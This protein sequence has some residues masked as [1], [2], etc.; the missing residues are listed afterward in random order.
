MWSKTKKALNDR[1]AVSLKKH[2]RYNF[3]VYVTNKY[4]WYTE[5]PV[6]YIYVD[7][8]LWFATNPEYYVKNWEYIQKNMDY[9]LTDN[10][11]WEAFDKLRPDAVAY[12]SSHGLMEIDEM[13]S[14]IHAYLNIFS[15]KDCLSSGNY[16]LMMLAVLDR[17]A[18]KRKI[19][20][21][22]DDIDN[23]PEWL[24]KFIILRAECEGIHCSSIK[25]N[26]Q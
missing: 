23:E 4:K 15:I 3:E 2:V 21:L 13:M 22:L 14:I 25:E 26:K 8:E 5:M 17:R 6:F 7:D 19:K 24:R 10:E 12:A 16:I 9:S 11:Y 20:Q 18:G 1:M